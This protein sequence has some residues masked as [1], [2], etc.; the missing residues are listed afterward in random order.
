MLVCASPSLS[1]MPSAR[2]INSSVA[3]IRQIKK[4]KKVGLDPQPRSLAPAKLPYCKSEYNEAECD[5]IIKTVICSP[6]LCGRS[7]APP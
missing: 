3:A 7:A 6:Y 2:P 4:K 1:I 5:L